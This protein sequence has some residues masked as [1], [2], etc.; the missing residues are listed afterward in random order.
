MDLINKIGKHGLLAKRALL[1]WLAFLARRTSLRLFIVMNLFYIDF[2]ICGIK[3][4]Y[5]LRNISLLG[6]NPAISGA[7]FKST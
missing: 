1:A 5:K 3:F 4:E 6:V 7:L 2:T